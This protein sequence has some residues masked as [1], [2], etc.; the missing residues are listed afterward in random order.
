MNDRDRMARAGHYVSGLMSETERE[1][2]ER[3]LTRDSSF[4]DAVITVSQKMRAIDGLP[5]IDRDSD[6]LWADVASRLGALPQLRNVLVL[7]TSRRA[8]IAAPQPVLP[9]ALQAFAS[10]YLSRARVSAVAMAV[11]VIF[12]AGYMVG[13]HSIVIPS[14]LALVDDAAAK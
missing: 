14:T 9:T 13:N 7:H 3:D 5:E 4:R 12:G 6:E 1:R 8:A 11:V 2:A 10:R